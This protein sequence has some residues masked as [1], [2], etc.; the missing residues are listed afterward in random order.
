[1]K[2]TLLIM[3]ACV[4]SIAMFAADLTGK[5]IYVNP[6][7]GSW[8]PNDRPNATIPYPNLP[9]TGMP[10]TL[11]FYESNTNLWKCLELR[12]HLEAAG[13]YVI[14]SRTQSGP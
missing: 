12:D 5:R 7:H 13:A 4:V 3:A 2:K 6:G 11:G 14:M 8:G 10:D 9:T 1:M